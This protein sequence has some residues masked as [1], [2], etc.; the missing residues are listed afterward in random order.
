MIS[1]YKN[2]HRYSFQAGECDLDELALIDQLKHNQDVLSIPSV[3]S[4]LLEASVSPDFSAKKLAEIILKDPSLSAQVLRLAN[5]PFYRRGPAISTIT[6]AITIIGMTTVKCLALA[7]SVLRPD[8]ITRESG[9]DS[10]DFFAGVLANASAARRFAAISS[11]RLKEEAFICGLLADVGILYLIQYYPA[12]YRKAVTAARDGQTIIRAEQDMLGVN[13]C[14]VGEQLSLL[15]NLPAQ[16]SAAVSAHHSFHDSCDCSPL[17]SVTKLSVLLSQSEFDKCGYTREQRMDFATKLMDDL[18]TSRAVAI[19]IAQAAADDMLEVSRGLG[20]D[21]GDAESLLSRANKEIWSAYETIER[22]YRERKNLNQKLLEK[23]RFE[24]AETAREEALATLSHYVNNALMKILGKAEQLRALARINDN[25]LSDETMS[26][27]E[28]TVE[29]V[30]R[31]SAVIDELRC[32]SQWD[33]INRFEGS[34]AL[35][36]DDRLRRRIEE[37]SLESNVVI[38]KRLDINTGP[39]NCSEK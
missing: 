22:L 28:V 10:G 25:S 2:S 38:S 16:I 4:E 35:N 27:S 24:A 8:L 36:I 33:S 7:S 13:H 1:S 19:E 20:M 34:C 5:S 30:R 17:T 39:L 29:S 14:Q 11:P 6:Q 32:M 37:T 23:E 21:I 12:E 9:V 15:W 31:I 18:G 26:A 3:V